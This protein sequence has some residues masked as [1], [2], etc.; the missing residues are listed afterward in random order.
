MFIQLI[1]L[2]I[3]PRR[4]QLN[5]NQLKQISD[6]ISRKNGRKIKL[7]LRNAISFPFCSS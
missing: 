3:N 7:K 6:K 4:C 2:F 5:H 1:N